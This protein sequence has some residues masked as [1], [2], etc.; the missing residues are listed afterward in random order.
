MEGEI[1]SVS[2]LKF[3]SQRVKRIFKERNTETQEIKFD[4]KR[5]KY[6]KICGTSPDS[7]NDLRGT[8]KKE[9]GEIK[10]LKL[11]LDMVSKQC[12][13]YEEMIDK[14]DERIKKLLQRAA[15]KEFLT[16]GNESRAV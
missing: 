12:K 16:I 1:K 10:E 2:S 15:Q 4:L 6:L 3:D 13:M 11:K 14:M 5:E 8:I 7:F 9:S